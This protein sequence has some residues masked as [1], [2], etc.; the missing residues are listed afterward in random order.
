MG[1]LA[2]TM[3]STYG[4]VITPEKEKMVEDYLASVIKMNER[5]NLTRIV[6]EQEARILHLE[7]SRTADAPGRLC[8]KEDRRRESDGL[9]SC[10]GCGY[11]LLRRTYRRSC[12]GRA[13]RICCY[14]GARGNETRFAYRARISSSM[15][16]R[17]AYLLQSF[18]WKRRGFFRSSYPEACGNEACRIEG[19]RT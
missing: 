17:K 6:H 11:R 14:N 5:L 15:H 18:P 7:D 19:V 8:I 3:H 16:G 12:T 4:I 9:G 2:D 13:K 1:L 10:M